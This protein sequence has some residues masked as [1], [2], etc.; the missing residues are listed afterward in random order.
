MALDRLC[1]ACLLT[2]RM[3]N[4]NVLGFADISKASERQQAVLCR[5]PRYDPLTMNG[6]HILLNLQVHEILIK[7]TSSG[8]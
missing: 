5:V 8:I 1:W 3:V 2:K 7:I 6:M 4:S